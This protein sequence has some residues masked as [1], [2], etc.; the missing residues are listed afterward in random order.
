VLVNAVEASEAFGAVKSAVDKLDAVLPD[1]SLADETA[2]EISDLARELLDDQT[3]LLRLPRL[4]EIEQRLRASHV[5]PLLD[6][7]SEG[8]SDSGA[9]AEAFDYSRLRSIQQEVL[10]ADSKLSSFQASR[11]SRYVEE[12]QQADAEHIEGTPARVARHIAERAVEALNQNPTQDSLIRKEAG[13]KTRHLPLRSLFDQAPDALVALRPCWAMSPLDVAQTLPPRPLFDLVVFDEASQVLPCDA[14]SALLRGHRAMVAGDSRQLPPT[15]FFDSSG[16]EDDLDEDEE[17][18]TDYESILDVMDA[19]LSRRPLTWH[20]RSQDE[21]LIAYS[22]Q[23]IYH[24]SLTTFPGADT[25]E[26]L[27]LEMVPHRV[28]VATKKGSNSDEVL[29]VVDLMIGHAR[30]CP[31]ETL[32]VIAMGLNHA[33]R[34]EE[35]L[36]Q[37]LEEESN[38]D[39]EDFFNEAGDERAFVKNLERV[40]GDERDAI[41]LSIGYGK[42][43]N[44]KMLYNFGPL[45]R[46]GGE[47]RLNVAITRARKRMTVVT[48]FAYAD[49]DPEKTR[50]TGAKML[51]GFLK[52]AESGGTE[53]GGA[54][55]AEPLNPF[56]IDILHKLKGAGLDLVPQYGCSGYRIDFAVRHPAKAGQFALA[57][58]ADGAS[59]HSSPTARDRDRLRQEHLERLGWRFCRIWSTDWFND[60]RPEVERV[61]AAY[62]N[63]VRDIDSGRA[64]PVNAAAVRASPL[65]ETGLD[66][67]AVVRKVLRQ[68]GSQ[69]SMPLFASSIDDYSQADLSSIDDYSQA[70]LVALGRWIESDGLLRTDVQLFD[71][72]F[73]ELPFKRRGTKIKTAIDQAIAAMKQKR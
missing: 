73:D 38:P 63:A 50:S 21:R 17:S 62:E 13:K 37:R 23:E 9:L 1:R 8:A 4:H 25:D 27:S 12:F 28:G 67:R 3:T 49:M 60:H 46:E 72:I 6:N 5:G 10:L 39:L 32:G 40:Q 30:N 22:N 20:Y 71:A 11:Q 53:L 54:D 7:I 61:V 68:R 34:I 14:I 59:Y 26:C 64:A 16:D 52:F 70:D 45:N 66:A 2:A 51:R 57:V 35:V 43:A 24:G 33:N 47:R 29:R 69:L 58:E 41:I 56:E 42:N 65:V 48:S 44:G 55:S 18:L 36:R 19:R 31:K 15:T